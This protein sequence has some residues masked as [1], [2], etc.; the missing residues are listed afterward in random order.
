MVRTPPVEVTTKR[1]HDTE[2]EKRPCGA[3]LH[4][5]DVE[6]RQHKHKHTRTTSIAKKAK[7]AAQE[8]GGAHRVPRDV[9]ESGA[10]ADCT[11]SGST[12]P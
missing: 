10:A 3:V 11:T 7:K 4:K 1:G 12:T 9:Y 8:R 5:A 2:H 6:D